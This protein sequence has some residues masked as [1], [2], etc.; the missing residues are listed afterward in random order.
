MDLEST[1]PS[2]L[3]R[4]KMVAGSAAI[5]GAT[6][7]APS[8]VG[9]DRV[10]AAVGTCGVPP[11]QLDWSPLAGSFPD[12][13]TANDGTTVTITVFDPFGVADPGFTGIVWTN[14][15]NGLDN[16]LLIAMSNATAGAGVTIRFDFS[17]P[18]GACFSL[19]DVDAAAGNWVDTIEL[20][21]TNAGTTV[22]LNAG[23]FV[24]GAANTFV[25]TN[26][27][28]G[29]SATSTDTGNVA[30]SYPAPIDRLEIE[31]RDDSNGTAFQFIGIHDFSW[32]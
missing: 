20:T 7:I 6:W 5:G 10:A 23:D 8:I 27:V 30:V 16:P 12:M 29:I 21:G 31:H 32:C 1:P 4:R 11:L 22:P 3:S 25:S 18:V 2:L 28:M 17:R 19:V 24:T 13:V 9:F 26:T 14:T 15:L